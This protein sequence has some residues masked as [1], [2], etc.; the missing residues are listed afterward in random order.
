MKNRNVKKNL[1]LA[2]T[3]FLIF[4]VIPV[5]AQNTQEEELVDQPE[6]ITEEVE[7]ADTTAETQAETQVEEARKHP[8]RGNIRDR[9]R[10]PSPNPAVQAVYEQMMDAAQQITA[11]RESDE[12]DSLSLGDLVKLKKAQEHLERNINQFKKEYLGMRDYDRH[13][14]LPRNQKE[15]ASQGQESSQEDCEIFPGERE[16]SCNGD[17][18][19]KVE[20]RVEGEVSLPQE[21]ESIITDIPRH[22]EDFD[23]RDFEGEESG[24]S[25]GEGFSGLVAGE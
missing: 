2:S 4:C 23:S 3:L 21:F 17:T 20:P 12:L 15:Q 19:V 18:Y 14:P 7:N 10:R 25:E 8:S 24:T 5:H 9:R 16:A 11:L 22:T 13:K 6:M 1:F